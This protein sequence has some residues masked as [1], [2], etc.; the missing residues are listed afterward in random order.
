MIDDPKPQAA[1]Q[2][3]DDLAFPLP[4]QPPMDDAAAGPTGDVDDFASNDDAPSH[5]AV[6]E[7][8]E[9][10]EKENNAEAIRAVER[11]TNVARGN[12]HSES[13]VDRPD[14]DSPPPLP[15]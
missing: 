7:A 12:V 14:Q 9:A 6:G 5:D 8:E 2:P 11:T 4:E 10:R 3:T 1:D 13:E 15:N